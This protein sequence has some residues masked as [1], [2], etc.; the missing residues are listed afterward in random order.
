M[1]TVLLTPNAG[2]LT[3]LCCMGRCVWPQRVVI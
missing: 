1:L 3:T 2:M